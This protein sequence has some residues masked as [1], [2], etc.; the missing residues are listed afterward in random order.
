MSRQLEIGSPEYVRAF[1]RVCEMCPVDG[2]L[3]PWDG[4][5]IWAG[6]NPGVYHC[7]KITPVRL[8]E[9]AL[10]L[11]VMFSFL[12][13]RFLVHSIGDLCSGSRFVGSL[14]NGNLRTF[15]QAGRLMSSSLT[16]ASVQAVLST[17]ES[18]LMELW[19][20]EP[21]KTLEAFAESLNRISG[22]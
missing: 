9:Y 7:A 15:I 14:R 18:E 22:R 8:P 20:R 5:A 10:Q 21:V 2:N 12:P 16:P 3:L 13:G 19:E 11:P 6:D 4:L 17:V 1:A